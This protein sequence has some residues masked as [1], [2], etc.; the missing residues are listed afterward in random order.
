LL[1]EYISVVIETPHLN[2]RLGK[3]RSNQKYELQSTPGPEK[4][5]KVQPEDDI[6]TLASK[7]SI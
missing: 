2:P 1:S 7:S 6:L 3:L 5:N 4:Y